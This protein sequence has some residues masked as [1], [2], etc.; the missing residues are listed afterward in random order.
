MIEKQLQAAK[1]NALQLKELWYA[2]PLLREVLAG[3]TLVWR[4]QSLLQLQ[5]E[6]LIDLFRLA[7]ETRDAAIIHSLW[8]NANLRA[9]L[10]SEKTNELTRT[11]FFLLAIRSRDSSI[12]RKLW[13]QWSIEI[14]TNF[15]YREIE[16]SLH[17]LRVIQSHAQFI[18]SEIVASLV[19]IALQRIDTIPLCAAQEIIL[20]L[21]STREHLSTEY[22]VAIQNSTQYVIKKSR[23][24]SLEIALKFT[25]QI[26]RM[27][28]QVN[29]NNCRVY[30]HTL[31]EIL[32]QGQSSLLINTAPEFLNFLTFLLHHQQLNHLNLLLNTFISALQ[33]Y[34]LASNQIEPFL[35]QLLI[36][37]I[38]SAPN[39][40]SQS[41][42]IIWA[43][44]KGKLLQEIPLLPRE[45]QLSL[46]LKVL[47]VASNVIPLSNLKYTFAIECIFAIT[48]PTILVSLHHALH[49][50]SSTTYTSFIPQALNRL[51]LI[52]STQHTTTQVIP[53]H[54]PS[55][56]P[57]TQHIS[58]K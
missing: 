41:F 26:L 34:P 11:L 45:T 48:E 37:F 16:S 32:S 31:G 58:P 2:Q 29:P 46:L 25:L 38:Q 36:F 49:Q 54:P 4:G 33:E 14:Q 35:T 47:N 15:N 51:F 6:D 39:A 21:L 57:A 5:V 55:P 1:Y 50:S 10:A 3:N 24:T 12:I 23:A 52:R 30:W 56:S 43:I 17:F 19:S 28:I 40:Y 22:N 9:H 13:D 18:P 42:L 53:Y 8:S 20:L 44:T 7:L 27:F